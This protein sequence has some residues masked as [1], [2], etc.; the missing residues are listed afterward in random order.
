MGTNPA[1]PL[2]GQRLA[3]LE[4]VYQ[5]GSCFEAGA[6]FPNAGPDF[7]LGWQERAQIK[8]YCNG[9]IGTGSSTITLYIV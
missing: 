1:T 8:S 5:P 2:K 4:R 3:L 9:E 7:A 6:S